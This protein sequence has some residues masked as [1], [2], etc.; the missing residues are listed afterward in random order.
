MDHEEEF[1]AIVMEEGLSQRQA[2][3][4]WSSRDWTNVFNQSPFDPDALRNAARS[5]LPLYQ[6]LEQVYQEV[7]NG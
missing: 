5:V 2:D 6:A 7:S 1:K 3:R 4:L